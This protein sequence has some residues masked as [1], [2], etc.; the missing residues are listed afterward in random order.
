MNNPIFLLSTGRTGT[1]FFSKFFSNYCQN[2]SSYHT[3]SYTRFLNLLGNMYGM[4]L[5]SKN[6]VIFFW[7]KLK[8]DEIKSHASRYIECNPYYYNMLDV[9][10]HFFP[11][12]KFI[13]IVRAPKSFICSH[14]KWEKQRLKSFIANQLIP[15]W[16][17]VSYLTQLK[18]ITFNHYQRV[19]FYSRVWTK[20]NEALLKSIE[21]KEN[22]IMI[23]F[24]NI[25]D[26]MTGIE[27]IER[28]VEWAGISLKSP[29]TNEV[30]TKKLN[31]TKAPDIFLWDGHC[32]KIMNEFCG[33]LMK[34]MGYE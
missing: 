21:N 30:I 15:F 4:N 19:E 22:A 14:I 17:P 28:L 8:Y 31:V 29:I 10:M 2:I 33:V 16:Q 6:N 34:K 13:I 5:L 32:D 3:T 11:N 12:A 20:K 25:F 24:E 27:N 23:K 18:G 26:P 1:K 7:K 9:I